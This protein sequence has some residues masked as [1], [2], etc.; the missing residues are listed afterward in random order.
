M[1]KRRTL[2]EEIRRALQDENL[3]RALQTLIQGIRFLRAQGLQ[4]LSDYPELRARA[5]AIKE[6]VIVRLDEHLE[7]L[8]GHIEARGGRVVFARDKW[9]A[10][11]AIVQIAKERGAKLIVKSKSMTSEEIELNRALEAAGFEV[12]ETDLGERI[13]QLARER[14][15][16]L[17][18]PAVHKTVEEVRELFRRWLGEEPPQDPAT[19]TALARQALREVFFSADLGI[20]GANFAVAETGHLALVEN[21]GNIR[22]T[23]QL[24]KTHVALMGIEKLVPTLDDL[25]VMLKLLPRS[26]TGQKLTSYVSLFAPAGDFHL[27]VLDNGRRRLRQDPEL[28]QA[29][30]CIRCGACLDSCPSYQAV[31]G[32]VFGG[33]T[34]MGGIGAAWTAGVDGLEE[35][36]EFHELCTSCGR[37]TEVCPIEIDIPWLNTVIRHRVH[38]LRGN[39]TLAYRLLANVD[40]YARWGSRLAPL[41]NQLLRQKLAKR[42]AQN[43]LGLDARRTLPAFRRRTFVAEFRAR[44]GRETRSK[45]LQLQAERI[46]LFVD[47]FTNHFEPEVAWAAV[48]VLERLGLSVELAE[49]AC[50]GRAALSQGLLDEA[51]QRAEQNARRLVPLIERGYVVVGVEPS[52]IAAL[53][54]EYH[55]LLSQEAASRLGENTF[56]IME[57]LVQLWKQGRLRWEELIR[58]TDDQTAK[59]VYHGHCHQK[60]LGTHSAIVEVLASVPGLTV[61]VVDVSCCGMAGSFGYKRDFYELS[62]HLGQRLVQQLQGRDEEPVA[63]GFSCRSQIW[64]LTGQA[65]RHPVQ[66]LAELL[67]GEG[68]YG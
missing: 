5:R 17:I 9:A 28:Q 2:A 26:G 27:I 54:S 1:S 57:Y 60:A 10:Q 55:H 19:L 49:N 66:V 46:A 25:V 15:S 32:H 3:Q 30:Y 62:R 39:P 47:C 43:A 18:G 11:E 31:G 40:R 23:A 12:V 64:D 59:I 24:P 13:V 4:S 44:R 20:T 50:C 36:A 41:S 14:P 48:S 37:C 67:G 8:K 63:S 52:C 29:L 35:A 6:D 58:A 7:Q 33:N 56:E 34:Y 42:L 38:E 45:L 68:A 53:R 16:H 61:D 21:E 22:L 51:R 65:V